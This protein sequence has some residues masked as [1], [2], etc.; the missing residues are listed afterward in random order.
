[1]LVKLEWPAVTAIIQGDVSLLMAS[2]FM[3]RLVT[4]FTI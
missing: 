3:L 2:I 4:A 1:M